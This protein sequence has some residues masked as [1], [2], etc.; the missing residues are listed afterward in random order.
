MIY[1]VA[2]ALCFK[3]LKTSKVD[4]E[5]IPKIFRFSKLGTRTRYHLLIPNAI[6][7]SLV[8]SLLFWDFNILHYDKK[9]LSI[10]TYLLVTYEGEEPH[11]LW[12]N[13]SILMR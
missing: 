4:T 12:T 1:F 11:Q 2:N 6:I 3:V 8:F 5:S 7:L 10:R 13:Y 9:T